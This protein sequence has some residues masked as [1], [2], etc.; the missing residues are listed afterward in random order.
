[1]RGAR[2]H[3][4]VLLGLKLPTG[5]DDEELDNGEEL[6]PSSQP[7]SGAVDYQAGLAYSRYLTSRV[8]WDASGV[9]TLRTEHKDFQVGD[10]ADV[11]TALNFRLT[12]DVQSYPN[13]SVF[14]ELLG[15]WLAEDEEDGVDNENSGG[16]TLYL[17]LGARARFSE[18]VSLSL[19]PAV[20]VW[21]DV[22]GNQVETDA[23]VALVLS[24]TP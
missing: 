20:A 8:T 17:S 18:G 23:K 11:A 4:A 12:E 7:G 14:G 22:N 16:E 19:A 21:Q 15:V 5:V 3:L 9:Y 10:R 2:G 13:W 1:M 24:F 6:E